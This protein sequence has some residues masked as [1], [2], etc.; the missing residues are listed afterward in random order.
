MR[1]G[2]TDQR[3]NLAGAIRDE[4]GPEPRKSDWFVSVALPIEATSAAEAVQEFWT[5]LATL[6]PEELPAF[7]WP[8][9]DEL[10]MRAFLL[11]EEVNLDPE[12]D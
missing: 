8:R 1:F 10:A 6:G 3:A 2:S 7:V 9:G 12:W 5:Y 4:V 11:G